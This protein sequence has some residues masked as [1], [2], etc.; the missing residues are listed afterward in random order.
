ML[1]YVRLQNFRSCIDT[2]WHLEPVTL[3]IGTN[4][5]GKSNLCRALRF[6]SACVGPVNM[7][8]AARAVGLPPT[9]VVHRGVW[10]GAIAFSLRFRCDESPDVSYSYRAALMARAPSTTPHPILTVVDE[11][12]ERH[13]EVGTTKLLER[14]GERT[15]LLHQQHGPEPTVATGYVPPEE[16]A[17]WHLR[18]STPDGDSVLQ[19]LSSWRYYN[20]ARPATTR[21]CETTARTSRPASSH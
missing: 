12:V 13:D 8:D 2:E 15:M 14:R 21:T 1:T 7:D 9:E 10:Q 16:S 17:L 3:L 11:D 18:G 19:Q 4:N 6:L 20:L 5:A